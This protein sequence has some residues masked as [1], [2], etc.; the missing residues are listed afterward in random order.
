MLKEL[1]LE[2]DVGWESRICLRCPL[3]MNRKIQEAWLTSVAGAVMAAQFPKD[4]SVHVS[5]QTTYAKDALL[6]VPAF[7]SVC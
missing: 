6:S 1:N 3:E 5:T 2:R 4:L 7:I